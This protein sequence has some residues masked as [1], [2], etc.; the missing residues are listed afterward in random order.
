MVYIEVG[1]KRCHYI[2]R[3]LLLIAS[4]TL[5]KLAATSLLRSLLEVMMMTLVID[6][7]S[8]QIIHTTHAS[9]GGHDQA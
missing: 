7:D 2:K 1:G 3:K 8:I 9:N 4:I 5:V 6:N